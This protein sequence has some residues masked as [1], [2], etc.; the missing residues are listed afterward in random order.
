MDGSRTREERRLGRC[1]WVWDGG[2]VDVGD[3]LDKEGAMIAIPPGLIGQEY[4][5]MDHLVQQGLL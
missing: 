3:H 1:L 2:G 4:V 5:G